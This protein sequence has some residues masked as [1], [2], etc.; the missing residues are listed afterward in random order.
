[1]PGIR[2]GV[3]LVT[4]RQERGRLRIGAE[5]ELE[6]LHAREAKLVA[7]R[8]DF[9]SDRAQILRDELRG[10]EG[11]EQLRS[12]CGP[13]AA[14]LGGRLVGRHFPVAAE[15]DEMVE[16][17]GVEARERLGEALQPPGETGSLQRLPV[18]ERVAPAL[19]RLAEEIR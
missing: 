2:D 5:G 9:R 11:L 15:T 8:R 12:R 16:A 1:R 13:P 6:Q 10:T 4:V 7:E 3:A 17:D 19:P 14:V 18:V